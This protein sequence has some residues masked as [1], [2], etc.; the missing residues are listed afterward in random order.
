MKVSSTCP[1]LF[2]HV[3]VVGK[4]YYLSI[5]DVVDVFHL[6]VFNW[7][8]TKQN[9]STDRFVD[10]SFLPKIEKNMQLKKQ[11]NDVFVS[12]MHDKWGSLCFLFAFIICF[13]FIKCVLLP[14]LFKRFK[15]PPVHLHQLIDLVKLIIFSNGYLFLVFY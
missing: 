15:I 13:C 10:F 4:R 6:S 11:N 5:F 1:S 9:T 14:C 8:T 3:V 2:L 7:L 12:E